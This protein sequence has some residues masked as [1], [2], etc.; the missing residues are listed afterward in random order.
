MKIYIIL[1]SVIDMC[2]VL[3]GKDDN[4]DKEMDDYSDVYMYNSCN[5]FYDYI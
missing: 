3:D 1:S 5:Y 2:V 4:G